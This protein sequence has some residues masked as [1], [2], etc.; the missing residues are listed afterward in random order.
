MADKKVAALPVRTGRRGN[1][2]L[3]VTSRQKGKWIIPRGKRSK[4]LPDRDAAAREAL[5]EGGVEGN[6]GPRLG[7]YFTKRGACIDVYLLSVHVQRR[8]WEEQADRERRWC[9]LRHA[10]ELVCDQGLKEL[11]EGVELKASTV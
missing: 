9:S 10:R 7:R 1:E 6:I 11:L 8:Q 3:L 5:Q 2:I 4:R